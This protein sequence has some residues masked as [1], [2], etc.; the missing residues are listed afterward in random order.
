MSKRT[1]ISMAISVFFVIFSHEQVLSWN[2]DIHQ[3]LSRFAAQ[4]TVLS[5]DKGDYLKKLK[6]NNGLEE[7]FIWNNGR[8]TVEQWI[9]IGA[10]FEDAGNLWEQVGNRAR[11]NNHFHN[12]L[13]PWSEAGLD[14]KVLLVLP[15]SGLSSPALGPQFFRAGQ[16]SRGRL[17]ME[18]HPPVLLSGADC[19]YRR[20]TTGILRQGLSWLR[21]STTLDSGCRPTGSC[22]Q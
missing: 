2:E 14:D 20:R 12:P 16:V 19:E 13:K 9:R 11:F 8:R 15:Y 21:T 3:D 7:I 5:N 1:F 18:C 17:V 22:P 4:N 10:A 6:F